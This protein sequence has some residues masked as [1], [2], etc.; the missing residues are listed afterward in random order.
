MI[1]ELL[2]RP[3]I[4]EFLN[5]YPSS[6]WTELITDLFEIGVLNLRNSYHRD[7]FSKNELYAL[8]YDLEHN[9]PSPSSFQGPN[10]QSSYNY[11]QTLKPQYQSPNL[12][13]PKRAPY[14]NSL[15]YSNPKYLNENIRDYN[16]NY[17]YERRKRRLFKLEQR[18]K[19][20]KMD[21][22]YSEKNETP[23]KQSRTKKGKRT[24]REISDKIK[25]SK[26]FREIERYQI[27][28]LK[29]KYLR[30]WEKELQRR[31]REKMMERQ[32][33]EEIREE[34]RQ[35]KEKKD[36]EDFKEGYKEDYQEEEEDEEEEETDK[37]NDYKRGYD[38]DD[39]EEEGED[40]GEE[41]GGEEQDNEEE[42]GEEGEE[43]QVPEN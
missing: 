26:Q 14:Y 9:S 37:Y 38:D 29:E 23:K 17:D 42:E 13:S 25:M 20:H 5:K 4:Q 35:K 2:S 24:H 21:A 6:R 3:N 30:N 28:D 8:I 27:K 12:S 16:R 41:D 10:T 34:E 39:E 7:E 15:T 36:E 11:G 22:F 32:A 18:A 43:Q 31:R 19:P 1:N 40:D 33:E